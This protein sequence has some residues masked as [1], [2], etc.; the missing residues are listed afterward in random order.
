MGRPSRTVVSRRMARHRSGM[1]HCPRSVGTRLRHRGR[2][3]RDQLGIRSPGMDGRHPH[4]RARQRRVTGRGAKTRFGAAWS[5]TST[6]TFSGKRRRSVGTNARRVDDAIQTLIP[7]EG[8]ALSRTRNCDR[9]RPIAP[10]GCLDTC[11]SEFSTDPSPAMVPSVSVP[12]DSPLPFPLARWQFVLGLT[13]LAVFIV[14]SIVARFTVPY[15]DDWDWLNA[16]LTAPMSLR[17]LFAPHNEHVIPL[18][19]IIHAW[20]YRLEGGQGWGLLVIA[21]LA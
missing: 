15:R 14:F 17:W 7:V 10:R 1:G 12:S 8:E 4:D 6:T 18:A 11:F 20:Q 13:T 21:M 3:C 5:R 16:I 19:R 9:V 2:D